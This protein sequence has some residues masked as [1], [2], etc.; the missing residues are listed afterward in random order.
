MG[1]QL[2]VNN[3]LERS[4]APQS[5]KHSDESSGKKGTPKTD[6][7]NLYLANEGLVLNSEDKEV[8]D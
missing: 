6:R 5:L 1:R 4:Q 3:A 2:T 8:K 7:R